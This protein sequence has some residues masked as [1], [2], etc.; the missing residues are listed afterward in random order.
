MSS[1]PS[2]PLLLCL[3][4]AVVGTVPEPER[5]ERLIELNSAV[6]SWKVLGYYSGAV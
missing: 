1:D 4:F 3:S 6:L 5:E 2:L